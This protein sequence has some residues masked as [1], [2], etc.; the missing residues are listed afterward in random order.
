MQH[1]TPLAGADED[2]LRRGPGP[3]PEPASRGCVAALPAGNAPEGDPA[4]ASRTHPA[5]ALLGR[6]RIKELNRRRDAPGLVFFFGHLGLTCA[7]GALLWLSRGTPW[8][9]ATTLLHGVVVVHWF[10]PFH[11]CAHGTAFRTRWLNGAVGFFAGLMTALLPRHFVR[12]HAQHHAHTQDPERDPQRI[13]MGERP[14]GYLFYATG[15]PYFRGLLRNLFLLPFGRFSAAERISFPAPERRRVQREAQLMVC[16]YLLL[17]AG[18]V[19]IQSSAL[20]VLW[21]IPR[22]AGEPAMRLIRMAEHVGCP[23]VPDML[24]NTRTVLTVPWLRWLAWNNAYHAEHHNSPQTP[25]HALPRLHA[26][27]RP[28]LAEVRDGYVATQWALVRNAW[29]GRARA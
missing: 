13:A 16:V 24:R 4:P 10:S 18:S 21:L 15:I 8:V 3:S 6:E 17:A 20:L 28:H 22:V 29:A 23:A 9:A 26:L 7:T 14:G 2:P 12:E 27:L 1:D 5:T 25:F 11:E 19:W